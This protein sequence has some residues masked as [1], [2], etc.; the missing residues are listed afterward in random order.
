[1]NKANRCKT[2]SYIGHFPIGGEGMKKLICVKDVEAIEQQGKKLI[3]I[4]EQTIITPAAKDAANIFGIEFSFKK[5]SCEITCH[6]SPKTENDPIDSQII[7]TALKALVDKGLLKG[8]VDKL[9]SPP[10]IAEQDSEGFKVLRGN[11]VRFDRMDTGNSNDRVFYQEIISKTESSMGA[12]FLMIEKSSFEKEQ[13]HEEINYVIDGTVTMGIN[14]NI[15]TA[16]PGD[17]IYVPSESK[18]VWSSSDHAKIFY[19]TSS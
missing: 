9:S 2:E 17:V 8:L 5:A 13:R 6:D 15:F 1:M 19:I 16:Y 7:Y 3:Y 12:G 14:G 10:Y 4:D 11:S 18:V